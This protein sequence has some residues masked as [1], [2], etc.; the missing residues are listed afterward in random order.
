MPTYV[1]TGPD[2]AR[3]RVTAPE[4]ATEQQVM[5]QVRGQAKP[6][7][8]LQ[9]FAEGMQKPMTNAV[10]M[11][12]KTNPLL[13]LADAAGIAGAPTKTA[14][15]ID[16]RADQAKARSPYRG[17]TFGKIAGGVAGSIPT[18]ALPGGIVAQGAAGGALLSENAEDPR[19]LARDI[20]IGAVTAKAGQ[21]VGKRV[22]APVA[23]RIGRTAPVRAVAERAARAVNR[24]PLP[25]PKISRADRIVSSSVPQ[26]DDIRAAARDAADLRLPLS[27]ADTDPRLRAL[28]GSVARFSPDARALAE[29]NIAPRGPGQA[30]RAVNAIDE[31]LAPVTN[32][33]QRADEIR[34]AANAV[35]A[36]FYD[37][38]R[39]MAAPVDD[40]I[41]A[42][43]QRPAG[44]NAMRRAFTI[45]QNEGRDP[46]GIGFD[47]NEQGEVVLRQAP[48]FETLQLIKRGLDAEL[49]GFRNP[50][51]GKLALEG[52]PEAQAINSMLSRFN[53]RLGEL[54]EPYRQGNAAYAQEIARRE[55]LKL[56]RDTAANNVPQRQFEEALAR[57]SERTLPEMQRGYATAM[58][59]QVNRQR[60][61]ANPY[62]AVI[63]SPLQQAKVASLFPQGAPRLQ[64]QYGLEQDMSKTL[65]EV[66]GG[67]QT[68]PRALTDEMFQNNVAGDVMD[69]GI[70]L[71]TGGVPGV[72]RTAGMVGQK[73]RDRGQL[74]L[75][76]AKQK[77]DELAPMLFDTNPSNI[78]SL[79]DELARKKAEEEIRKEAYRN[80]FGLLG[81]PAAAI[82]VTSTR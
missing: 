28:A 27:L 38:A 79:L 29:K 60:F 75:L 13:M 72:A 77:A 59:D 66:L 62:N 53:Q 4:G 2:G 80:S 49:G 42:L 56:G 61:S 58:A 26:M 40:E 25:L 31:L 65:T 35:S 46:M 41:A 78:L 15:V 23:E 50:I 51:T 70:Q 69:T 67:S 55:S 71:A 33:E 57:Q 73:L 48:S 19:T 22:L 16:T 54:N 82:G 68:Q 1:V 44:Q 14:R 8:F 52:N 34:A 5:A 37:Q 30:D 12:A 47:L 24:A 74:G 9:G 81:V 32:I 39:S 11:M 18:A 63:G 6:T 36:P 10:R 7:S 20:A 43:L 3:Y 64:R 21:Q 45:A 76:G 17:S